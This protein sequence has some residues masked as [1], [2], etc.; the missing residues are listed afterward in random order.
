MVRAKGFKMTSNSKK[1]PWDSIPIGKDLIPITDKVTGPHRFLWGLDTDRRPC[2][3]YTLNSINA[4]S[5]NAQ[6]PK[7]QGLEIFYQKE[8][9]VYLVITLTD[10]FYIDIFYEFCE[11]LVSAVAS[12]KTQ[13]EAHILIVNRCWRWHNFLHSRRQEKLSISKQ[14]GLFAE[15]FILKDLLH[16]RIGI[17]SALSAW[18][19]PYDSPHDFVLDQCSIEV[20]SCSPNTSSLIQISSEFQL[21]NT[22]VQCLFL[23]LVQISSNDEDGVSLLDLIESIMDAIKLNAPS[24]QGLFQSLLTEAGFSWNHDYSDNRWQVDKSTC[25]AVR[26]DFPC[27]TPNNMSSRIKGVRYSITTSALSEYVLS[28]QDLIQAIGY[29]D[30]NTN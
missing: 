8:E 13:T 10:R 23:V 16:P 1:F 11:L 3:L 4:S 15:L 28:Y 24:A 9:K 21:D 20:K 25:F 17:A 22:D 7:L 26:D 30:D 5:A 6:L 2:L 14:Q 19:G 18:R 12:E 27:I 29:N